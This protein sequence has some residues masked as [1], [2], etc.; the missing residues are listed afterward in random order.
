MCCCSMVSSKPFAALRDSL[1]AGPHEAYGRRL[2]QAME[3]PCT[4]SS[5]LVADMGAAV[6]AVRLQCRGLAP[7]QKALVRA[8]LVEVR[9]VWPG[10]CW[11]SGIWHYL[12]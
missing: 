4:T 9:K 5:E 1:L 10:F 8:C 11:W 3:M 2:E 12:P 6:L 7:R